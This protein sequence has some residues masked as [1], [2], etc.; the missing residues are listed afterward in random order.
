MKIEGL[1]IIFEHQNQRSKE[2]NMKRV[3]KTN[4]ILFQKF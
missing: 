3:K 1:E 4:D 2:E